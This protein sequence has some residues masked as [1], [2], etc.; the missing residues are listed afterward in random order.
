[1]PRQTPAGSP[2]LSHGGGEQLKTAL[3]ADLHLTTRRE[4]PGRCDVLK[5]VLQ[6]AVNKGA[7]VVIIAGDL[8]DAARLNYAEFEGLCRD[9]RFAALRIRV[10]PSNHDPDLS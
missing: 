8:I 9:Q 3:T 10:I 6:G 5:Y 7:E 1:M 2:A 4:H